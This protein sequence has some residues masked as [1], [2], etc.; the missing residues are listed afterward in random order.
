MLLAVLLYAYCTGIRSSRR[1]ERRCQE[2]IAFRCRCSR[3]SC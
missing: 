1:I 2:D 3:C